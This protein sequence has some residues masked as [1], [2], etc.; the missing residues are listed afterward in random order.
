MYPYATVAFDPSVLASAEGLITSSLENIDTSG[1]AIEQVVVPGGAAAAIL[2]AAEEAELVIVGSRGL[3]AVKRL[4]LG[5][6]ATQV[7]HHAPCPVA[8]IPTPRPD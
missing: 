8:V 1:V 7:A 5:S 3:G 6:V 2:D 4:I